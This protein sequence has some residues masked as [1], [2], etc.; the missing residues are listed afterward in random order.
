MRLLLEFKSAFGEKHF[1]FLGDAVKVYFLFL[2]EGMNTLGM[3]GLKER[4]F[5]TAEED[6]AAVF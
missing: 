3:S 6:S 2:L 1:A 4:V 5:F